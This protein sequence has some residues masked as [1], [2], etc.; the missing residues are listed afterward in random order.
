MIKKAAVFTGFFL[1][2]LFWFYKEAFGNYLFCFGDLTYYFYPYRY[3]MAESLRHGVLP[4]WNPYIH[5]G[6]PFLATLQAG[7]FYPFSVLYY[8]LPFNAAFNWFLIV[9]YPLGGFFMYMLGRELLLSDEGAAGAGLV[10][11]F[12][13][14]LS[15]VLHMP[16]TLTS[17]VWLPL[18]FLYFRRFL[19][20]NERKPKN[21]IITGALFGLMFLGGEPTILYGTAWILLVY[22]AYESIGDRRGLALGVGGL[23]AALL[24]AA[25]FAAVQLLPFAE[26]ILHSVRAGGIP[27]KE[28]AKFS[29]SW[30][31]MIDLLFPYFS[32]VS[33]YPWFD[34]GWLKTTYLG[35]VPALLSLAALAISRGRQRWLLAGA[36]LLI[37]LI[38]AG[39]RS[40]L[41]IYRLLYLFVPGFNLF[42]YPAKFM[43]VLVFIFAYLSGLGLDLVA[44]NAARFKKLWTAWVVVAVFGLFFL[45]AV[46]NQPRLAL[47]LQPL[48][49][50][51]IAAWQGHLFRTVTI[52]RATGNLAVLIGLT[53]LLL[54]WLEFSRR[55]LSRPALVGAGLV[56]LIFLDLYTA[57]AGANFSVKRDDYQVRPE[58]I[59]LLA[60]DK[61]QFRYF[62]A[63]DAF[64]KTYSD[65][66]EEFADWGRALRSLRNRLTY[67]QN[68]IFGL[69]GLDGYESIKG[70]DQDQIGKKILSLD[71]LDGI[72]ALNMLNVK[73]LV[74][75]SPFR[76]K[77]YR[78]LTVN[79]EEFKGGKIFLYENLNV[80]PRSYYVPA[81]RLIPDRKQALDYVFSHEF[82]PRREVVLEEKVRAPH[83]LWF[84]S[85]WFYPG[86]KA[87]VDG[88]EAKIYRANYMFRAVVLP[89][90]DS[91]VTYRYDPLSFK[92]GALVSLLSLAGIAGALLL[93]RR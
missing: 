18:V 89:R 5:M 20:E 29:F 35:L 23:A 8:C 48:F 32:A 86:W 40:P 67:D 63:P 1:L 59:R 72:S 7:I 69:A 9:H 73:Y 38:I 51:E 31:K 4:L 88:Q 81:A 66:I 56:V 27:Y 82:D 25:G 37:L 68:M 58:N 28:A 43:F 65:K 62:I 22:L 30:H 19:L 34:S 26:L 54:V 50:D 14:Y 77:G 84:T 52:P 13:G 71:S 64:M 3:F 55:R 39:D 47:L 45:W 83:G 41:P 17:V 46:M 60:A 2:A 53:A 70:E 76:Q 85:E 78:L 61:S 21:L 90:A 24:I 80:L 75:A 6:F 12:S 92:L 44:A 33:W 16:T 36:L 93:L 74:T 15:S 10:F 79:R 49:A 91:K 87:L 42:R 11:A 57:N